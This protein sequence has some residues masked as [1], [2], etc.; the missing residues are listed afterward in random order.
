MSKLSEMFGLHH[1]KH[2]ESD[3]DGTEEAV[4][5]EKTVLPEHQRDML[6]RDIRVLD[7]NYGMREKKV[8]K[9]A[10]KQVQ[11]AAEDSLKNLHM[12]QMGRCPV[13]SAHLR[14]H[15]FATVC[16]T[17]DFH[18]Y[19]MP[20]RGSV[21]VHLRDGTPPVE[22]QTCYV[23]RSGDVLVMRDDVI[24]AKVP[25][26]ALSWIEYVWTDEEID[27]RYKQL[28]ERLKL[29]CGWCNNP[30]DPD[31]DGFHLAQAAFGASQERYVFCCDECYEA[32]RRMYPARVHRNCYERNC[33]ECNDCI[34]RY[35]DENDGVRLVAKDFLRV[36]RQA[37]ANH[38][39]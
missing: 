35:D 23:I 18:A 4:S 28:I 38:P 39:A 1:D 14:Q 24:R 7:D 6:E 31:K 17:C 34:K 2:H 20:R 10:E 8:Q 22:G 36:K 33:A 26:D 37:N 32:F 30:A 16:E 9:E 3:D 25:S 15:L 27:Q 11:E 29:I 19:E 21:R 5:L 13:C 12:I